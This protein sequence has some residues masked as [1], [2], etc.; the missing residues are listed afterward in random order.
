MQNVRLIG[1]SAQHRALLETLA[2]VAPTD[3]EVLITGPSGVGKELYARYI[4]EH[5]GRCGAAFVPVNC[6][7]LASDLLENELFGHIGGA[8]TGARP[9]HQGLVAEAENGTLFLD[10]VDTLS[11]ANQVKLLRF[12]QEKEYRRLG[13]SRVRRAN[14]RFVAATNASLQEAVQIG[15]FRSDLFFRLRVVPIEVAPLCERPEDIAPLWDEYV[16]RYA[17]AY[18]ARPIR[19]STRAREALERYS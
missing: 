13:E 19:L 8:F 7:T 15:A 12:V 3:A 9:Q 2:K 16:P 4:H 5:S 11:P 6:G 10:E 17:E 1:Q 14:V 18:R